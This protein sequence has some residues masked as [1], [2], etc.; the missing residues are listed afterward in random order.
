MTTNSDIARKLRAHAAGLARAGDNLYRV[1]AF[2][3]AALVV[4]GLREPVEAAGAAGLKAIPG[5][6]A[7]L[8]ETILAFAAGDRVP[9]K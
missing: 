3:Q 2:R 9:A 6:G 7:S 4:E 5:I 1:R 8:A